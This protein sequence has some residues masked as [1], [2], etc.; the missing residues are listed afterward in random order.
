MELVYLKNKNDNYN[1]VDDVI[2]NEFSI[3]SRLRLKLI[4]NN[5]IFLN[6]IVS[7]TR[8][9][10]KPNDKITINLDFEE[11]SS[12]II[13][14]KMN[15]DIMYE[16]DWILVVNKPAGIPVH[17]SILHYEDSLSNGIKY[18]FNSISLK[19]KIRPVNRLDLNTSGLV[20]FAKCEYIQE[21]LSNQMKNNIFK[22]E[23]LA[24]AYGIFDKKQGT[25]NLPI[26]RKENSI[27]ERCID[28]TGQKSI[29][30]Y[31]VLDEFE[32]YSLVKCILETGRTHQ[33]RVHMSSINHPLVGDGVYGT[34]NTQKSIC[35]IELIGQCLHAK[36]IRFK[37][38]ITNKEMFIEAP[39][40][41][42]FENII[43]EF[44]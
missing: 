22:K 34:K 20:V 25:I 32:N 44:N 18:Y 3:S 27:I 24:L 9:E 14:T 6:N 2:F 16:D 30:H 43:K 33:I 19:K 35:G 21:S 23:Y 29:T 42:Y 1:I 15:L 28:E 10:I 12:N 17:P 40:P 13:P 38:P 36:S 11:E 37:H 5:K 26:A 4:K 39:L 41:E 31:E 7:D 8:N